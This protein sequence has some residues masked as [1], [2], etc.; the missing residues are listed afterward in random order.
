MQA[1]EKAEPFYL[2]ALQ[3]TKKV[4]GEEH[5]D[6]VTSLNSLAG[7]YYA[8][9]VYEKAEPLYLEALRIQEHMQEN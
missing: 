9:E 7:L 2:E 1:Y 5:P 4:L 8:M 6:Y 3:V